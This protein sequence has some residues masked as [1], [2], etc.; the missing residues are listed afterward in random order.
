MHTLHLG[1]GTMDVNGDRVA[2][3]SCAVR[4]GGQWASAG[5]MGGGMMAGRDM[6]G[7]GWRDADDTY[8]MLYTL[9]TR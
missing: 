3:D 1:G 9:T 5:M 4:H 2:L 7:T 8:G 6:M